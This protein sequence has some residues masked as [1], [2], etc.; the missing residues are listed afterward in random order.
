METKKIT[1]RRIRPEDNEQIAAIIRRTLEEFGANK[2]GTVYYDPTTDHLF[3]L[4]QME[5]SCYFIA[6]DENGMIGGAGIYPTT[7]LP[8][9]TVELVKMYILTPYRGKGIGKRLMEM[10]LIEAR[11]MGYSSVYLE[12]MPELTE[13]LPMYEKIGFQYLEKPMGESGH[14]GCPLWMI[15]ELD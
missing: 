4:F 14:H 11:K 6:E 2:P 1:Y 15:R 8:E 13:A 10:C 7:G 9:S 5:G 3:E 12:T